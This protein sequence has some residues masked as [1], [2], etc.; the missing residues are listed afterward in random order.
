[1]ESAIVP[2][3]MILELKSFFHAEALVFLKIVKN[4]AHPFFLK[5]RGSSKPKNHYNEIIK[6]KNDI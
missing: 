1:M 4:I 5:K 6:A 2:M 3:M